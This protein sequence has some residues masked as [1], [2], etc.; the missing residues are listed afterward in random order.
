MAD[1]SEGSDLSPAPGAQRK[2]PGV[3]P[4]TLEFTGRVSTG[5]V[6][7]EVFSYDASVLDRAEVEDAASLT[8]WLVPGRVAWINVVGLHDVDRVR[9]IGEALDLPDLLLEDVLNVRQRPKCEEYGE[10]LFA[11]VRMLRC[12]KRPTAVHSEQ[13]SIVLAENFAV[14]FQERGGDVFDPLRE[15]IE[16]S[17]GRIRKAGSDYLFYAILDA[18]VDEYFPVTERLGSRIDA[19]EDAVFEQ[20]GPELLRELQTIRRRLTLLRKAAWPL[21]DVVTQLLR[22]GSPLIR[23]ETKPFL[24]DVHDHILRAIDAVESQREIVA[25][26]QDLLASVIGN[27]MNEVMKTLTLIATIFIPLTFLA[28]IYGM[29]F[30]HMPELTWPWMYPFAFWGLCVVIGAGMLAYFRHRR[31]L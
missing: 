24:R 5:K 13:L 17:R 11:V 6:R 8:N 28:G 4:G 15:R 30:E 31:W 3:A 18:V 2:R 27:R 29:N 7:I 12:G 26:V 14:T 19:L 10:R 9:A 23:E 1:R 20:P 16:K 22:D 21:R 25:G